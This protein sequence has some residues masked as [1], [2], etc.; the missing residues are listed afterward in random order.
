MSVLNDDDFV[1]LALTGLDVK[2]ALEDF[3]HLRKADESLANDNAVEPL[4][5]SK[6][7]QV[8]LDTLYHALHNGVE[9]ATDEEIEAMVQNGDL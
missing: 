7:L 1:V 4:H 5:P 9:Q 3:E 2:Q 8:I 6:G